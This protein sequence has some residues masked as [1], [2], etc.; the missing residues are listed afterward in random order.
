MTTTQH[1][2]APPA[3]HSIDSVKTWR[4]LRL[5]MVAVVAGLAAA[6]LYEHFQV[7]G[8]DCF[9]TSISAYYYTPARG[10]FVAALVSIGVAMVCLRGNTPGEDLLL[11]L[12]GMFA[13]VVAFVPTLDPG[14]CWSVKS[15]TEARAANIANN[16]SALLIVGA[17]ALAFALWRAWREPPSRRG[18]I[19]LALAIMVWAAALLV[20]DFAGAFFDRNGHGAA[21][22]AMFLC[23]IGVA[24]IN[25]REFK[26]LHRRRTYWNRYTPIA[27]GMLV[28]LSAHLVTLIV[29]WIAGGELWS[30]ETIVVESLLLLLFA[31]FWVMQTWELWD[32]GLRAR[33]ES[34]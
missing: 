4:Y 3:G 23:I 26:R 25:V 1:D 8:R 18:R 29:H 27:A 14:T 11:N 10:V 16:L 28:V 33:P 21:A 24:C 22:T 32:D 17:L 20:H 31:A 2:Q 12:G 6:V 13:P 19:A 5:S 15:A 34:H 9:Q 30:H 7:K